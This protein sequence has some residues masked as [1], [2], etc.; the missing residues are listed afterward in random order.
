MVKF[1][2]SNNFNIN[3]KDIN[4]SITAMMLRNY[5]IGL[6]QKESE[7]GNNNDTT[8][9][10]NL[11]TNPNTIVNIPKNK[12]K[13]KPKT[14]AV[15]RKI[16][17]KSNDV[18]NNVITF[19]NESKILDN[20]LNQLLTSLKINNTKEF[21]GGAIGD[22]DENDYEDDYEDDRI[23]NIDEK[24][25][26]LYDNFMEVEIRKNNTQ[27]E[28]KINEL[29]EE[30]NDIYNEIQKLEG[31]KNDLM[32]KKENHILDEI[33]N[34]KKNL[35]KLD[36]N[37]LRLMSDKYDSLNV[38]KNKNFRRDIEDMISEIDDYKK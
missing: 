18:P 26:D 11:F 32:N 14:Y 12:P 36:L 9:N 15:E 33:D 16:S 5:S 19:L 25:A 28:E 17:N 35:Y 21:Y 6:Q 7:S 31:Y 38:N 10:E 20:E 24:I 3:E 27:N 2:T 37:E 29:E 1:S 4:K 13:I 34:D 30:L 22:D 8:E 23:K